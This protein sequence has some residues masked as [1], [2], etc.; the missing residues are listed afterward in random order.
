MG[1]EEG[2]RDK[3]RVQKGGRRWGKRRGNMRYATTPHYDVTEVFDAD[4]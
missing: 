4:K 2:G 1:E 3:G